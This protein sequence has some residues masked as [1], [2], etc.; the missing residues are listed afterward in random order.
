[1][2]DVVAAVA[3]RARG[4]V[5]LRTPATTLGEL[6][7]LLA[8]AR[9]A[10][11]MD[12]AP[13]HLATAVGTPTLRLFGPGDEVLYGPWGDPCLHRVARAPRAP[14]RTPPGSDRPAGRIRR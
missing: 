10:L 6:A 3:E 12:S 4:R 9:F 13:M 11:G 7:G 14:R 5:E 2:D 1:E 8:G